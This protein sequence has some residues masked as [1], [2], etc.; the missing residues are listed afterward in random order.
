MELF[1]ASTQWATRPSDQRFASLDELYAATFGYYQSKVEKTV[2]TSNMRADSSG[3]E[4][5]LVGPSG[6]PARFTH[7]GFGQFCSLMRISRPGPEESES[8]SLPASF[9][10]A[11][12]PKLAALLMN[13]GLLH[14]ESRDLQLLFHQNGGLLLRAATGEKYSRYWNYNVAKFLQSLPQGWRV[15]PAFPSPMSDPKTIRPATEADVLQCGKFGRKV[16]VGD[17]IAPAGIYA[18]DHN[19]FVFMVNEERMISAGSRE[20]LMRGFFV[21]NDEVGSGSLRFT[22]F[23]FDGPCGNHICWGAEKVFEVRLRHVGEGLQRKVLDAITEMVKFTNRSAA[24][25]E[26]RIHAAQNKLLGQT[27]DQV[28]EMVYERNS[29]VPKKRA[30]DA[31]KIAEQ[32]SDIHGDPRSCWGY[33]S[34]LTRLSQLTPWQDARDEMDRAARRVLEVALR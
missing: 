21:T 19:M 4:V 13:Y 34:G 27:K 2:N 28:I 25:D 9:A 12:D 17:M 3:S 32:Y 30:E 8:V 29:W 16:N 23:L 31:F 6:A 5:V 14:T 10:R 24:E 15:P 26:A 20:N 22:C 1:A 33:M 18:S 7:Y 11:C